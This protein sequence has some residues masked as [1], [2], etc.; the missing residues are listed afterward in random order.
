MMVKGLGTALITIGSLFIFLSW[1]FGYPL[2]TRLNLPNWAFPAVG[3][4]VLI[5]GLAIYIQRTKK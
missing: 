5:V 1:A 4:A 3:F 2:Y